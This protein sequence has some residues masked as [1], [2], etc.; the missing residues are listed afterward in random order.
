MWLYLAAAKY[1]K[2]DKEHSMLHPYT[3]PK[4]LI[5]ISFNVVPGP[6]RGKAHPRDFQLDSVVCRLW[7]LRSGQET[8]KV[9]VDG[10]V[11]SAE[12][13]ADGSVLTLTYGNTVAFWDADTCVGWSVELD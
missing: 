6:G 9:S 2:Q 4:H 11:T 10:E 3:R 5:S 12:L 1:P 13:C 7:D 8:K